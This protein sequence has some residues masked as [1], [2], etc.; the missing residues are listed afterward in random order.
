MNR[1]ACRVVWQEGQVLQGYGGGEKQRKA[2]TMKVA[3]DFVHR[4]LHEL[5]RKHLW[6]EFMDRKATVIE[7]KYRIISL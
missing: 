2:P 5:R 1:K 3:R 4:V 7:Q 6:K